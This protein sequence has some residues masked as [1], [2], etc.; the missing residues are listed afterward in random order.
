M[1]GND[2][3][4]TC[5]FKR[6]LR[7]WKC[8]VM[9]EMNLN[10]DLP[11]LHSKL[12]RER[13]SMSIICSKRVWVCV[14]TA[15]SVLSWMRDLT[16]PF[17]SKGQNWVEMGRKGYAVELNFVV[18][19]VVNQSPPSHWLHITSKRFTIT[20][21]SIFTNIIGDEFVIDGHFALVGEKSITI[22]TNQNQIHRKEKGYTESE[23]TVVHKSENKLERVSC[24]RAVARIVVVGCVRGGGWL[25]SERLK[26]VWW[27]WIRTSQLLFCCCCFCFA[28]WPTF[29]SKFISSS[30]FE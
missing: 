27:R 29:D 19:G 12:L 1:M 18:Y 28:I 26:D 23:R 24:T 13:N 14:M 8:L 22:E 15:I 17:L 6:I 20:V 10:M 9:D 11:R 5:F 16:Q 2:T 25:E 30:R 7:S 3:E 21:P 4:N